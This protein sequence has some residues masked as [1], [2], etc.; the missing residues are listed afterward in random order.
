MK[1]RYIAGLDPDISKNA[2]A[3]WDRQD[4]KWID[5]RG[6]PFEDMLHYFS[7]L[8]NTHAAINRENTVIYVEAGWKNQITNFHRGY[9]SNAS[10]K[11]AMNIGM[12]H[13]VSMLTARVLK[14]AGWEVVEI[15]PVGKA[16]GWIKNSK[17][18]TKQGRAYVDERS[19]YKGK[20]NDDLRDSLLIVLTF[21]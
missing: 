4:S 9:K 8:P 21:R 20:I 5:V 11:I 14:S 7:F 16:K 19:G 2:I 1:H 6:V 18:W 13:A 3:I 17:G 15:A 10:E 12:N